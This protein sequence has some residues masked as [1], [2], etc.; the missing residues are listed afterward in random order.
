MSENE[1]YKEPGAAEGDGGAKEA[2]DEVLREQVRKA[3]VAAKAAK[4][5][6]KKVRTKD[7]GLAH[8]IVKF[9]Q[10]QNTALAVLLARLVA[11]N[12]P[13]DFLL[14]L[15]SLGD[16]EIIQLI[17]KAN[18]DPVASGN[19]ENLNSNETVNQKYLTEP[20]EESS[21]NLNDSE[22]IISEELKK[23]T[24]DL[25]ISDD[26][27]DLDRLPEEAKNEINRWIAALAQ[28]ANATPEKILIALREPKSR[29]TNSAIQIMAFLLRDFLAKFS[30]NFNFEKIHDFSDFTLSG[31]LTRIEARHKSLLLNSGDED[32]GGEDNDEDEDED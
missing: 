6:E 5:D 22:E 2:A 20:T 14:N 9:L 21:R 16:P 4:K 11:R 28:S 3:K 17:K 32:N 13:A 27:F 26:N 18:S 31:I 29:V 30:L 19:E 10:S 24:T 7:N 8:V 25:Q 12:T 23:Q 15:L 1:S